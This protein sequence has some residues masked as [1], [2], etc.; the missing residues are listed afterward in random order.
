MVYNLQNFQTIERIEDD[1]LI[2][3]TGNLI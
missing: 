2:R 3:L 1:I